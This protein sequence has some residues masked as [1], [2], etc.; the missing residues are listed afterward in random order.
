MENEAVA[1]GKL[2]A[3]IVNDSIMTEEHRPDTY[4]TPAGIVTGPGIMQISGWMVTT[5]V[6][7]Q[8]KNIHFS[9]EVGGGKGYSTDII[10]AYVD[11]Y[12]VEDYAQHAL[13]IILEENG[14]TEFPAIAAKA[15]Y[16]KGKK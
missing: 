11:E 8:E 9:V 16:L 10:A 5:T 4:E 2:F 14:W 12:T 1:K 7:I 13:D 6:L 3:Q 15:N